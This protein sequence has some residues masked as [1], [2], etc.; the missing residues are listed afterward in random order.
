L[1]DYMSVA[2]IPAEKTPAGKSA[3]LSE[4]EIRAKIAAVANTASGRA[5]GDKVGLDAQVRSRCTLALPGA[6]Q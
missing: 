6:K 1:E 5:A 3:T 2:P 4:E